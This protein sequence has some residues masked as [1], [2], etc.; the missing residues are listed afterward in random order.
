M[1]D[2]LNK[3]LGNEETPGNIKDTLSKWVGEIDDGTF[4]TGMD[5]M[6]E[7]KEESNSEVD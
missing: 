6:E 7:K 3:L 5:E 4:K 2:F 1:K